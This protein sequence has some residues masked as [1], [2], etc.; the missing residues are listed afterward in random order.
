MAQK[1]ALADRL[2]AKRQVRQKAKDEK[3]AAAKAKEE[4][5]AAEHKKQ[6]PAKR[7]LVK[8]GLMNNV[9]ER[10]TLKNLKKYI[11][12]GNSAA[13]ANQVNKNN[14]VE[15]FEQALVFIFFSTRKINLGM[16]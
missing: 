7:R 8:A 12:D 10:L 13:V 1:K 6:L 14:M 15:M 2:T 5:R 3:A 9:E 4:A 16:S 11:R